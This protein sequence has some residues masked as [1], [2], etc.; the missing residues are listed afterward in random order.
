[1]RKYFFPLICSL[2]LMPAIIAAQDKPAPGVVAVTG[3]AK[4]SLKTD[5]AYLGI[6]LEETHSEAGTAQKRLMERTRKLLDFLR[7]HPGV[8]RL[9]TSYIQLQPRYRQ[10]DDKEYHAVQHIQFELTDLST[11]DALML[12]LAD[13]QVDQISRMQFGSSQ[14][15]AARTELMTMAVTDARKRATLLA[16]QLD[17]EIGK[18]VYISDQSSPDGPSPVYRDFMSVSAEQAPG[19]A[20]A[21]EIEL[22]LQ[23]RVHFELN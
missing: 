17:Q 23:V 2:A 5:M 3:E 13:R 15:E 9:H 7:E 16:G 20:E 8:A 1:M 14:A 10:K 19:S 18:A 4:M 6:R 21:G 22:R 12:A 11:Y